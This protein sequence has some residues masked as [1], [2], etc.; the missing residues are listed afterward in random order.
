[1]GVSFYFTEAS[2]VTEMALMMA[3]WKANEFSDSACAKEINTFF[4]C[5][6]KAEVIAFY[7]FPIFY[8]LFSLYILSL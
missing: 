1:M 4:E 2:C 3:C 6:A 8:K 5:A 7:F